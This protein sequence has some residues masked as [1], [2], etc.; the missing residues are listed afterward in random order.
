MYLCAR[1][2]IPAVKLFVMNNFNRVFLA[3]KSQCGTQKRFAEVS[4]FEAIAKEAN[5]PVGGLETY[6]KHLQDLGLIKYSMKERYV[7][8][9]TFGNKQEKLTKE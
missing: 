9:T 6:F 1:P 7:H 3:V 2:S 4:N 5:V 8:L